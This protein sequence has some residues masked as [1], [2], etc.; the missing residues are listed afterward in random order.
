[1]R[2][3][4][5]VI[6]VLS[7]IYSRISN[8][9]EFIEIAKNVLKEFRLDAFPTINETDLVEMLVEKIKGDNS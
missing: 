5:I 2:L 9:E 6:E 3:Y 1:M 7:Y 8:K 4:T